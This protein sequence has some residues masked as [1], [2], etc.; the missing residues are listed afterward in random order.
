[1][2]TLFCVLG[3][4]MYDT[5]DEQLCTEKASP[6]PADVKPLA[7]QTRPVRRFWRRYQQK[8]LRAKLRKLDRRDARE[9]E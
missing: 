4:I 7:R 5:A 8:L 1:M 6:M 9:Q 2:L 3:Y